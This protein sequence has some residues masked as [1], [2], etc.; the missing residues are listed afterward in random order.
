MLT[1]THL[2]LRFAETTSLCAQGIR[3]LKTLIH[4]S[5]ELALLFF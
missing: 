3:D 2:K 5:L 1:L 4:E